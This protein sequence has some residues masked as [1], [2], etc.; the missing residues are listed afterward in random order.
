M[1]VFIIYI[2]GLNGKKNGKINRW[3]GNMNLYFFDDDYYEGINAELGNFPI[4][5]LKY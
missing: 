1:V 4:F 5:E 2:F 3:R